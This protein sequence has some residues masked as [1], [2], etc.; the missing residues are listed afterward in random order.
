[1]P[2][3]RKSCYF[4]IG[5][6]CLFFH[7]VSGQNQKVADS[8]TRIYEK[9]ALKDTAKLELLLNLSFNETN[10]LKLAL[11]YAEELISLSEQ[12]GNSLYLYKGYFLKGNK[13]KLLGNLEE[14]LD[15]YFKSIEAAYKADYFK[16]EAN[17]F[18][19]IAGIYSSANNHRNA[20]LYYNK[21]ISALRQSNDSVA[22]ASAILNAGDEFLTVK[23]YDSALLYFRESEII[24][25]KVNYLIGKA[26]SLGNIGMV[27][28][29]IEKNNLAEKNINDAIKILEE[30]GVYYPVCVYLISMSDIHHQ[31]GDERAALNY[32]LRSLQLAKDYGLKEQIGESSLTLSKLYEQAKNPGES[33]K[34]YKNHIAYRD[35]I[36]NIKSVQKMADLRTDYEISQKQI[37]LT[38]N[39]RLLAKEKWIRNAFIVGFGVM[40]FVAVMVYRNS[41]KLKLK[42]KK[43]TDQKNEIERKNEDLH[44]LNEEKN[45]LIGIVAHDLKSPINQIQGLLS[46]IKMTSKVDDESIKYLDMM[47]RSSLRLNEMISKILDIEA[48]ESKLLNLSLEKVN[49]S[50]VVKANID[51]SVVDATRK[52]IQFHVSIAENVM[53]NADLSY[54]DQVIENLLS[55]A[56]KFSKTEKNI[57]INIT[58]DDTAALCEIRD[59][60]PGLSEND[61]KKLF[62]KYQKLSAIPTGNESSTGLGLSIVKKFVDAMNGEIWCVSEVGKGTSFFVKFNLAT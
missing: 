33:L 25:E 39:E 47:E 8:L 59:E 10:D 49:F 3:K 4:L 37:E 16:G 40:I 27:Y 2:F 23:V 44:S 31:K 53:V 17:A 14:A 58:S 34:Y 48:I 5:F 62:K 55:N 21:A 30:L 50:E 12:K 42:N 26:Y 36:N 46:L 22:L 52:Q 54:I 41:K 13:K 19:A 15:A 45:N 29:N 35:S 28:A 51:R 61:K 60:G 43:I 9:D 6:F 1:M 20:M 38:E 24:F 32:A 18:G 57:Y 56:I 7:N 11:Q